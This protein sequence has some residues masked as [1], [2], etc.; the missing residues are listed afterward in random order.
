LIVHDEAHLSEPFQTLLEWIADRQKQ[1]GSLRPIRLLAMSATASEHGQARDVLALDDEDRNLEQVK[2]RLHARK[3]LLLHAAERDVP[4][5]L[6]ELAF[7]HD[8]EKARVI[9][10]VRTP[11][12]VAKVV[13]VIKALHKTRDK[14]ALPSERIELLTGTIRGYERDKLVGRPVLK[15]LLDSKGPDATEYLISTSA[16]EVGADFDA[17]HMVCDLTTIDSFIQRAGRVNRR[18]GRDAAIDLVDDVKARK[19]LRP[20][21]EAMVETAKLLTK[22]PALD[23]G[24]FDASPQALRD[25]KDANSE[26]YERSRSP[27]PQSITPHE[28][29]LDAWSLTSIQEDWPLAHE[30]EPYLHGLEDDEAPSTQ[31]AWRAELDVLFDMKL[32]DESLRAAIGTLFRHYRLRPQE[33][34]RD[35]S[36]NVA[37][38]LKNAAAHVARVVVVRR[39]R[40]E[41]LALSADRDSR[42]LA[43]QLGNATVVLP[44]SAGGLNAAGMLDPKAAAPI[45]KQDVADGVEPRRQRGLIHRHKDGTFIASLL[46]QTE[47]AITD[48]DKAPES[49]PRHFDHWQ[50]AREEL[51]KRT[52][53]E[54][55][56]RIVLVDEDGPRD[57]LVLF[58]AP[59]RRNMQHKAELLVETHH[60]H[61]RKI[62]EQLGNGLRLT[63]LT[64]ALTL[65][66][67]SHDLGKCWDCAD[68]RWQTAI[69]NTD[70]KKPLAKSSG[71][72]F[73][74][75]LLAGYRHEFGS[76]VRVAASLDVGERDLVLHLIAAHHGRGRPHF[77]E[78]AMVPHDRPELTPAEIARRF[79]RLQRKYGHWGLAWLEAVLMAADAEGSQTPQDFDDEDEEDQP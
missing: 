8:S 53:L 13:E 70:R 7:E 20:F 45:E 52:S 66:A 35:K 9:V 43:A 44:R 60:G 32:D 11:E 2:Q 72:G 73:N 3:R 67:A 40:P 25:L 69:G 58:R 62:V 41:I 57:M 21:E 28:A 47:K 50:D 63:G 19:N 39:G 10:F 74:S 78:R 77:D 49:A 30:A 59:F 71:K 33:L 29:T 23:D 34:L 1:D 61:V 65:A 76:L 27:R 5:Q 14:Q 48:D 16:G 36:G 38:L 51:E 68:G 15:H 75:R 31:V 42:I 54:W 37:D 24:R 4:A 22:L 64:D 79:D 17:D 12:T 55:F 6:A 18:G 26:A 46:D 56:D